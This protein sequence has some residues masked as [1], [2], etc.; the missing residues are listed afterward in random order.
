VLYLRYFKQSRDILTE[1]ALPNDFS[2]CNKQKGYALNR[3]AMPRDDLPLR[4]PL[5]GPTCGVPD[6]IY[7]NETAAGQNTNSNIFFTGPTMGVG[8]NIEDSARLAPEIKGPS[9]LYVGRSEQ[10]SAYAPFEV[11]PITIT[12]GD[13]LPVSDGRQ[14]PKHQP[15]GYHPFPTSGILH[16]NTFQGQPSLPDAVGE[17][18]YPSQAAVS[19]A[20]TLGHGASQGGFGMESQWEDPERVMQILQMMEGD[21]VDNWVGGNNLRLVLLSPMD[22]YHRL[23]VNS[24]RFQGEWKGYSMD[25]RG[26]QP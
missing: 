8:V 9:P 21:R 18:V 17:S 3:A 6:D 7:C 2:D 26:Q 13:G 20:M 24:N 11:L 25:F 5:S 4:P 19:E 15:M 22:E 23:A 10:L 12:P 14:M 16:G 1:L